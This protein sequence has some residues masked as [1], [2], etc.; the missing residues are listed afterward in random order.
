MILVHAGQTPIPCATISVDD[1]GSLVQIGTASVNEICSVFTTA[2]AI[3][4]SHE[5]MMHA[6]RELH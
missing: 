1:F 6:S 3:A 4:V 2:E 5:T